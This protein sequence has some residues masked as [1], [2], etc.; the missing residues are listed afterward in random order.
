MSEHIAEHKGITIGDIV[1]LDS[2]SFPRFKRAK[3]KDIYK[4]GEYIRYVVKIS[5]GELLDIESKH[6]K[7]NNEACSCE[8]TVLMRLGCQCGGY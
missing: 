4:E 8:I 6:I 1:K 7:F 3:V 5:N 2:I